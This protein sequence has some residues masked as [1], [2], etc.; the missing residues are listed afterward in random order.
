MGHAVENYC[1]FLEGECAGPFYK[2]DVSAQ[3]QPPPMK[4]SNS[5]LYS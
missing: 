4:T 5:N 2:C 1:L 3:T